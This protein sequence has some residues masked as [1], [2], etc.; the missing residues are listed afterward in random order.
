M[1][2]QKPIGTS[3]VLCRRERRKW[4]MLQSSE[5][6]L[7]E[8]KECKTNAFRTTRSKQMLMFQPIFGS[9]VQPFCRTALWCIARA[10]TLGLKMALFLRPWRTLGNHLLR[11]RWLRKPWV[12]SS[13]HDVALHAHV[14]ISTTGRTPFVKI[15]HEI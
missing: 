13:L 12:E 6:T 3:W 14:T 11:H 2:F 10:I 8:M 1:W 9:F 5:M 4:C 7:Q 15:P